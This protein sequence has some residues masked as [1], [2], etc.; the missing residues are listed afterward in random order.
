KIRGVPSNAMVCS[1]KELGISDEHE[2]IIILDDD[3]P[4]GVPLAD[5]MGDVVLT[6]EILP[7]IARY[8]AIIGVAREVAALTGAPF[9]G[10][11]AG[12]LGTRKLEGIGG[13]T[14]WVRIEIDD[15]DLCAR[16]SAALI[17]EVQ[18]APSPEW[19][20]RRLRLAGMR[21][22]NNI[23]DIT[24]YVMLEWGQPLHAFDYDKLVARANGAPTIIIRRAHEGEHMT[25]LDGVD[26]ALA[27][28]MLMIADTAGPIAVAGVMGG[29]ETEID[30]ET[31]NVL[32]ESASFNFINN[33]KTA[34]AL[35]LPSEAT[36]RFGR[37]VPP[38]HTI[39][40]AERAG[41]LMRQ[42]ARGQVAPEIADAYPSRQPPTVIEFDTSEVKRLLGIEVP[43]ERIVEILEALDFR[44]QTEG[45][46]TSFIPHGAQSTPQ[47]VQAADAGHG[48]AGRRTEAPF[49]FNSIVEGHEV[50]IQIAPERM[51]ELLQVRGGETSISRL[52]S[53]VLR[54]TVPDHRLDVAIPEDLVEEV[55]RIIG[56]DVIPPTLMSDAL[57]PQRRNAS[58]EFEDSVRDILV[59]AG[60]C[61]IIAYPLTTVEREVLL[62]PDHE[63]ADVDE[64]QYVQIANPI[65]PERK[66]MR[67]TLLASILDVLREALRHRER[68]LLFEIGRTYLPQADAI[69]PVERRR[70]SIALA[71][72]RDA[73]SWLSPSPARL[74][75]E[76]VEGRGRDGEGARMDFLHLKG[77]VDMLTHE[78]HLQAVTVAPSEHPTFHP[79]R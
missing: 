24:N 28:D 5:Y 55:G 78:L 36:A 4:V 79:A 6:I 60:L 11:D 9:K 34:Q 53:S 45:P 66:V 77:I 49:I 56:Y 32:L 25:T 64:S 44:V 7:N 35:K 39:P 69:L 38:A 57:P 37:G 48:Q 23:V 1:E 26:R 70:L 30:G 12:I 73:P 19:M 46:S 71:G 76:R 41:E 59:K 65:S 67:H 2:G 3:A 47:P 61:E 51:L 15:P 62:Y 18:I 16:Y 33:R 52:P 14:P 29:A 10:A 63:Q 74:R 21:P 31:K 22:I 8:Q 75:P 17:R 54:V 72:A 43:A 58:L 27:R 50:E 40:A 68:V 20:Q 13:N 42:L